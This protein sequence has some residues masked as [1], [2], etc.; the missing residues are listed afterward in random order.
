MLCLSDLPLVLRPEEYDVMAQFYGTHGY[1]TP[2]GDYARQVLGELEDE[3]LS[4]H[5]AFCRA[6][7]PFFCWFPIHFLLF[8]LAGNSRLHLGEEKR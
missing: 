3:N 2:R 4:K 8:M 6:W 7:R 5:A 1:I